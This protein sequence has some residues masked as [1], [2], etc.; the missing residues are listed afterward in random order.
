MLSLV[1]NTALCVVPDRNDMLLVLKLIV[2][3]TNPSPLSLRFEL[4]N[5]FSAR[6]C[7]NTELAVRL[8]RVDAAMSPTIALPPTKIVRPPLFTSSFCSLPMKNE[9][10]AEMLK[11]PAV[12]KIVE[13]FEAVVRL[14]G[15][16][17]TVPPSEEYVFPVKFR[18]PSEPSVKAAVRASAVRVFC[19]RALL[20]LMIGAFA[21]SASSAVTAPTVPA[22]V[23]T[24]PAFAVSEPGPFTVWLNRS[25]APVFA[26]SV[27]LPVRVVA[28]TTFPCT[29]TGPGKVSSFGTVMFVVVAK[30]P[31]VVVP[32]TNGFSALRPEMVAPKIALP[33]VESVSAWPA[34]FTV[35]NRLMSPPLAASVVSAT[36]LT[37]SK[38]F[39]LPEVDTT[40][41]STVVPPRSVRIEP[42]PTVPANVVVPELDTFS[43]NGPLTVPP[44][45]TA[46]APV[47][48][49]VLPIKVI[50]LVGPPNDALAPPFVRI[51]PAVLTADA[52]A[53]TPPAN[54]VVSVA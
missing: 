42:I 19:V 41:G 46:P 40:E 35:E 6:P 8:I 7:K 52:V 29:A 5:P 18:N 49:A 51:V 50:A 54:V 21:E 33:A 3:E 43:A 13:C 39:W 9:P 45:V 38:K 4:K 28:I 44:K 47:L 27:L 31:M 2:G 30:V 32:F 26:I 23:S 24:P 14:V 22:K 37:A 15:L 10:A 1:E 12:L 36:S 34:A 17:C 53:T 20:R 16:N 11:S 25:A 48:I